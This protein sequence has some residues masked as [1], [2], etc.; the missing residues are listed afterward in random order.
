MALVDPDSDLQTAPPAG[1]PEH[2]GHP[3][4]AAW[5]PW[6]NSY[7]LKLL[8]DF[9]QPNTLRTYHD[10]LSQFG[11]YLES[12]GRAPDLLRVQ[13]EHIRAWMAWLKLNRK[14]AGANKC[15]RGLHT[16]FTWLVEEGEIEHHP[17]ERIKPPEI[18]DAPVPVLPEADLAKLLKGCQ[19]S[20][21]ED[22]RDAALIRF[23]LD[24]GA[25]RGEVEWMR[26]DAV[27]LH[28]SEA[29]ITGKTGTRGVPLGRKTVV[30]I[31]RYLR[32]RAKH[33]QAALPWLWL[34]T[35]GRL[36]GSGIYQLVNRRMVDA[37]VEAEDR[38]HVFRHTFGHLW[39]ANGGEEGDLMVL[40]GW[41]SRA[42]LDR[43]GKSAAVE[44]A[45]NAHRR[46]SPGDR[47]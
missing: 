32:T 33:S 7:E 34:G 45:K 21:F 26:V 8:G 41:K 5:Q 10:I 16:F 46:F 12:Q 37:G 2:Y 27:A 19:G 40:G 22:R 3:L 13:A 18:P 23:L 42:M 47:F 6:W 15:Y 1:R 29:L 36:G 9:R 28:R 44:R 11:R 43:Y 4:P 14:P 20:G 39:R 24:T 30:A 35:K 25:R 38:V 31:D 17:M